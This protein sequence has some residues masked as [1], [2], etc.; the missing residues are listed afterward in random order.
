MLF[1]IPAL[2]FAAAGMTSFVAGL[3]VPTLEFE[4]VHS[5][6]FRFLYIE[7]RTLVPIFIRVLI[8]IGIFDKVR[9][10]R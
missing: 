8:F 1:W 7:G 9:E 10:E 2:R 3:I 4:D 5:C 6:F